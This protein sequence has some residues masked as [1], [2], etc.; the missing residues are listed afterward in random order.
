MKINANLCGKF[1][2]F[3]FPL[4]SLCN[5]FWNLINK[6]PRKLKVI[7]TQFN[8]SNENGTCLLSKDAISP[9]HTFNA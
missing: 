7:H 2:I 1:Y 5:S 4:S 3:G 6:S 9:D 8:V